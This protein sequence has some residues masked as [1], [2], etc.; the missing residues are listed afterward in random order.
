LVDHLPFRAEAEAESS[1]VEAFFTMTR[2]SARNPAIL[3]GPPTACPSVFETLS[4]SR[5]LAGKPRTA[6][7]LFAGF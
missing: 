1:S 7:Q 4:L 6:S 5:T 2:Q 3:R